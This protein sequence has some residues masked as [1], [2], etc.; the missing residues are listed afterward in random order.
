VAK[1]AAEGKDLSRWMRDTLDAASGNTAA[2][3]GVLLDVIEKVHAPAGQML[4]GL[5]DTPAAPTSI[6]E[7]LA[8]PL[9]AKPAGK[10]YGTCNHCR[11]CE[12]TGSQFDPKACTCE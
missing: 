5:M 10:K 7:K 9:V 1:A 4:M 6:P 8:R 2:R 3:E 12:R 11:R